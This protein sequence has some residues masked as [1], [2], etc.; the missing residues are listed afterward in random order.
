MP[1]NQR[2]TFKIY[3]DLQVNI[4][5]DMYTGEY[6]SYAVGGGNPREDTMKNGG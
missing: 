2:N 5:W 6:I 3:R 4:S 1:E